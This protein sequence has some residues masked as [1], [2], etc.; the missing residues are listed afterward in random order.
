[1]YC[2]RGDILDV[3]QILEV[4]SQHNLI[5]L[6]KPQGKYY[7]IYCPFHN[8]GNERRPS[9]GVLLEEERRRGT[10]YPQGWCHCFTCG[11]V[12]SLPEMITDILKL[13][14]IGKSGLD[15]LKENVPGFDESKFSF[16]P[17]ES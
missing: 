4:L 17:C 3:V 14:N 6:N 8:N 15:W 10:T 13:K 5:R 2:I 11:Y 9:F 16:D 1:M 12:K 7:S